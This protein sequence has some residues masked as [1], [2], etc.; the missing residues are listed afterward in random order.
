MIYATEVKQSISLTIGY[1]L[2][3]PLW[4]FRHSKSILTNKT[5]CI[6]LGCLRIAIM[7]INFISD[8]SVCG[9]NY[10]NGS[11]VITTP[12]FPNLYPPVKECIYLISQPNGTYVNMT[13][14]SMDIDCH[15][16]G[17]DYIEMWDGNT[18]DS[19]LIGRFCGNG[20]NM[21]AVVQTTQNNLRIR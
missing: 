13:V 1:S 8:S 21:P 19:Q 5:S 7:K 14:I 6:I 15:A 11:G 9:G 12:F 2:H 20:S 16:A 4:V 10:T 3:Y 17:S 18:E